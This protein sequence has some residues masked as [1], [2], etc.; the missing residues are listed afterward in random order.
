MD[1]LS[2][3]ITYNVHQRSLN[4]CLK[5]KTNDVLA[6]QLIVKCLKS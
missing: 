6:I 5:R 1:I 4:K 3:P 2:Q